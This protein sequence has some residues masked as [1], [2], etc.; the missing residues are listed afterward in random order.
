VTAI[1]I[2]LDHLASAFAGGATVFLT[3]LDRT[4]TRRVLAGLTLFFVS[5]YLFLHFLPMYVAV[6]IFKVNSIACAAHLYPSPFA[7]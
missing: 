4:A 3:V 6:N 1:A 7:M 5:H 2:K